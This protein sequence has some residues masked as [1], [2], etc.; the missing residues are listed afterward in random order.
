MAVHFILGEFN[1]RRYGLTKSNT[2]ILIK[3]IVDS[4]K[5]TPL[6]AAWADCNLFWQGLL[7]GSGFSV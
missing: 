1:I 3:I 5:A 7:L 4:S 2:I 6:S